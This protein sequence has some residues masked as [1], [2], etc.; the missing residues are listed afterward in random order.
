MHHTHIDRFAQGQSPIHRLDPRVKLAAALA[1]VAVLIS[2][3]RYAVAVLA[4]ATIFPFAMLWLGRIPIR[5]A[6]WRT[7]VLSP[8]VLMLAIVS[9][10]YDSSRQ[11]VALG[12]WQ[13]SVMGGYLTAADIALKFALGILAM[14]A[15]VTTTPFPSLL[16]GLRRMGLPRLL[17]MQLG[18]LWRY[19][20]VLTAEGQ[21][22]RRGRDFRGAAAAPV[23]RRLA[24]VGGIV[25][26]LFVRTLDRSERIHMAMS[27]RGYQ[28][29]PRGLYSLHLHLAD[30]AFVAAVAAYLVLC[31]WIY[32]MLG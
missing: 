23:S 19:L 27:V 21:R 29:E 22:I 2:F 20:F 24:A 10:L 30:A 15:L 16:E 11:L 28:G 6:L 9:P 26:S 4:P 17:V 1:Y 3:D 14:T 25:G 31:R 13:F 32:P 8:L 12:P 5:F 7:V 18:L